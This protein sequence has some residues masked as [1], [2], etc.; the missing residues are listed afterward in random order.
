MIRHHSSGWLSALLFQR[1]L[2]ST[3]I[4]PLDWLINVPWV[5]RFIPDTE[6]G[7]F[8]IHG[9][10]VPL[11]WGFEVRAADENGIVGNPFLLYILILWDPATPRLN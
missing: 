6:P 2:V 3:K 9:L 5:D 4:R 11:T 8:E 7:R 1:V 10:D